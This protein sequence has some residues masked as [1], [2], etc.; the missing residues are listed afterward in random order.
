VPP[1]NDKGILS[2]DANCYF[3]EWGFI[4]SLLISQLNNTFSEW[5]ACGKDQLKRRTRL[6]VG[7]RALLENCK[8]EGPTSEE[9]SCSKLSSAVLDVSRNILRDRLDKTDSKLEDQQLASRQFDAPTVSKEESNEKVLSEAKTCQFLDWQSWGSCE[10][11]CGES[12]KRKRIR[13]CPCRFVKFVLMI[14]Y[15][16]RIVETV[17][18]VSLKRR[19][20]AQQTL[21]FQ[22]RTPRK[23]HF[24]Y[25]F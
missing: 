7:L 12:G 2:D 10:G 11:L 23:I 14:K 3:S 9:K 22:L 18:K 24:N 6:C 4:Y 17:E 20:L 19:K 15:N 13:L 1:I 5:S 16:M 25:S 21:V 8:C